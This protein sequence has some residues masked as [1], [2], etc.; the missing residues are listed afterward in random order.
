MK[1]YTDLRIEADEMDVRAG[2]GLEPA[3]SMVRE[4]GLFCLEPTLSTVRGSDL[5]LLPRTGLISPP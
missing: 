3:L 1:S 4:S 2:V 5:F